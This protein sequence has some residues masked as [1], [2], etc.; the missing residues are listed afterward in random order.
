MEDIAVKVTE[1]DQ[2]T[3]SNTHRIDKLEERQDNLDRLVSS[4]ATLATEQE[5]IKDDVTEIKTDVKALTEKPAKRWESVVE[6]IVLLVVAGV[7]G[8]LLAQIG[9][10]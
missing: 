9:I 7:V 10:A 1:V 3:K 8:F 5:H 2:R 6:K 4:V